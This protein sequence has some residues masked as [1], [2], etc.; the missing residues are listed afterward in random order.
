MPAVIL[1][2]D[3][4]LIDSNDAHARSW[5]DA[6]SAH[7]VTVAFE[8]VRRAI[9]MGGD[10]LMPEVSG[11]EEDSEQGTAI[12][13]YRKRHFKEHYLPHL[14]PF[15]R[16][17][18]MVERFAA[19]GF[20]LVVASSAGDSELEPLLK[21]AGV[22]D[23][24]PQRTSSDD[25][26][27]SKPEPDIV[28]AALEKA[29]CAPEEAVMLGDTPYDIEAATRAGVRVV[30]LE[31]GGWSRDELRGAAEVYASPGDLLGQYDGS[32]FAQMR[33]VHAKA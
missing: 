18:E 10:K 8:P 6:F 27:E 31:S 20:S 1:D 22:A 29:S 25:A 21:Q 13:E 2:V 23:L 9:G 30:A 3:G 4:T 15:A 28:R 14:R 24:L 12:R 33:K 32:L 16:V 17:R 26:E 7:G 11:I 19:E 5:V